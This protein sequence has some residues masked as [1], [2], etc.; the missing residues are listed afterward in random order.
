MRVTGINDDIC[1][2]ICLIICLKYHVRAYSE[3]LTPQVVIETHQKILDQK[4]T[5]QPIQL[6]IN[7]YTVWN[8]STADDIKTFYESHGEGE[9][10][11]LVE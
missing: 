4:Q 10:L 7:I 1:N 5:A 9:I 8:Q 11:P 6:C 3:T 2:E